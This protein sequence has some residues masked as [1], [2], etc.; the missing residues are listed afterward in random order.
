[1]RRGE[2]WW[3]ELPQPWGSRPVL[4]LSRDEAY[5]LLSRVVVAPLTTRIRRTSSVVMVTPDIDGVSVRS[6]VNLDNLH[7]VPKDLLVSMLTE[8]NDERMLQ[9]EAAL[10]FALD[11][12]T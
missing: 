10:H 4:L 1:M 12:R 5:D 11:L 2:V 7:S 6:I 3:A 9:V 8:L